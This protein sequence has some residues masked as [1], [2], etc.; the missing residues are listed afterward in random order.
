M[1]EPDE[2]Q[3]EITYSKP[4][5]VV[6]TVTDLTELHKT[7][8]KAEEAVRRLGEIYRFDN[9]VGKS[10]S[11]RQVFS[12][13]KS[14]ASSIPS[15]TFRNVRIAALNF[16]VVVIQSELIFNFSAWRAAFAWSRSTAV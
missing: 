11:M 8:L 14:A 15:A 5:T 12:S 16:R 6:E 13:I 4:K 3:N 2:N 9:I 1:A 10:H 7:K